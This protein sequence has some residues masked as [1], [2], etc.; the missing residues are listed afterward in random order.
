MNTDASNNLLSIVPM[1][2]NFSRSTR[3]DQDQLQDDAFIYSNSIDEFLNTIISHRTKNASP[4][5]AFTWTGPYG[6]GK[7]TL[8]LSLLSILTGDENARKHAAQVYKS[9][10][11][12]LLWSAF[13]PRKNGWQAITVVGQRVSLEKAISK[14]LKSAKL[15]RPRAEETAD[16]IIES[17]QKFIKKNDDKGGLFLIIDEMGKLLEHAVASYQLNDV[18]LFQQIAEEATLSKGRFVL[19]GILHQTILD[20]SSRAIKTVKEEWAKVSGRFVDINLNLNSSEQIELISAAIS[21]QA[22]PLTHTALCQD[23]VEHLKELKRAPSDK[24]TEMLSSCWPLNPLTATCLGPISRRSYGQN[25]RSIFS[26]LGSGEPLGFK[27]FLETTSSENC[28][29]IGYDLA[30]LWDY[31]SFNWSNVISSSQDSHSFAVANEILGQLEIVV[32][33]VPQLADPVCAKIIKTIHLLQLTHLQTGLYPNR[34]TIH[35][36]LGSA[37][38]ILDAQIDRLQENNL[39]NYRRFNDTYTLH[40]GSDFDIEQA[41]KLTVDSQK[42]FS[43][44]EI[45][46]QFLPTMV[47][48]KRHYLGVGTLRWA[49]IKIG[50]EDEINSIIESFNPASDHFARF[51]LIASNTIQ[52]WDEKFTNLNASPNL[53]IGLTKLTSIQNDT[54]KEYN[55]LKVILEHSGELSKDKI[56]RR[57]INDRI[58]ARQQEIENIFLDILQNTTWSTHFQEIS[59]TKIAANRLV[60]LLAEKI[61]PQTLQIKN[62]LIN[63]TKL[64]GSAA[65]ALKKL[66]YSL[67]NSSHLSNLGY[68]KFPAER[69]I[70]ESVLK[71]NKIHRKISDR[72]FSL[73]LDSNSNTFSKNLARMYQLSLNFLEENRDRNIPLTELYD[74]IWSQPPFGLKAGPRPLFAYLFVLLNQTK[75]A[76]YREDIFLTQISEIDIDF[77]IRNP[78]LC[79]VRYLEMDNNT[80]HILSSLAAIPAKFNGKEITNIAP[81]DVARQLIEI[82]DQTPDWAK[83]T[84]RVSENAKSV[85]TLFKRASD[86]AQFALI[87]IPNLYG[88]VSLNDKTALGHVFR[89]IE[90]G[91]NELASIF[92]ETMMNFQLHLLKELGIFSL[93]ETSLEELKKRAKAIKKLSGDNRMEMFVTNVE[94]LSTDQETFHRLAAMLVNKPTKLWVDNDIVKVFVEATTF[95]RNFINLETMSYI[96]GNEGHTFA[97]AL[98]THKNGLGSGKIQHHLL[99]ENDLN[100]ATETV[101]QLTNAGFKDKS[102]LAAALAILLRNGDSNVR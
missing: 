97:F 18:Y 9:E 12:A 43:L 70:Y 98:V 73:I 26:F 64:S 67:L 102:K 66:L 77:I 6:S 95:C 52:N 37:A 35:L 100:E 80:K 58:D 24:L 31:L 27:Y 51:I 83:K 63:R 2:T 25:Q 72:E 53:A 86:P 42:N 87:D 7:S 38:R 99:S 88:E 3:I 54:I 62:E 34:K 19:V 92:S 94:Q 46:E 101:S 75:I 36:A 33:K 89:K 93:N 30:N 57:E 74:S 1:K 85:R 28:D 56:A 29:N 13:P 39:I 91:L 65:S 45:G 44:S 8:A 90:D 14:K 23:L 47:I 68:T 21:S 4:H 76:F 11:A 84:A 71:A 48:A 50:T 17:I 82:F 41:L 16:N 59:G 49:D 22:V 60:S 10:T 20:Y 61:Y 96:K 15:M 55:A 32:T 78:E 40:E 69:G 5:G 81:L 79:A